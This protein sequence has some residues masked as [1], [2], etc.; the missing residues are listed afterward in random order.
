LQNARRQVVTPGR[1]CLG[2]IRRD[3]HRHLEL[4]LGE[5]GQ[6]VSPGHHDPYP[7]GGEQ[8]GAGLDVERARRD[9]AGDDVVDQ[10]LDRADI[11]GWSK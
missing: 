8:V 6:L 2:A 7:A 10:P 3:D 11:A 4:R 9:L 5:V 1:V